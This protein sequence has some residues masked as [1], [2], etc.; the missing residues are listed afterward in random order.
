MEEYQYLSTEEPLQVPKPDESRM[1]M[2]P[3]KAAKPSTAQQSAFAAQNL[4]D[5]VF[6][7]LDQDADAC[8]ECKKRVC[9][10][11]HYK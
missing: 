11:G 7:D 5:L 3:K 6:Y 1:R 8:G 4:E 9:S 2:A 10:I